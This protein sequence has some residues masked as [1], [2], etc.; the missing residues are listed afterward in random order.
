[1]LLKE[2]RHLLLFQTF[3]SGSGAAAALSGDTMESCR[4]V[5]EM[6]TSN[7]SWVSICITL[8]EHSSA[9]ENFLLWIPTIWG[10][11]KLN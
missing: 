6:H 2:Q 3:D 8:P 10:T 9:L 7:M 5:A 1:M 4:K 11:E